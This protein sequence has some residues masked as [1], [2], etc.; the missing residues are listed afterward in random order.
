MRPAGLFP[1]I[2][3][4]TAGIIP[5][6]FRSFADLS[7]V[8]LWSGPAQICLGNYDAAAI[9][10]YMFS[11]IAEAYSLVFSLVAPSIIRSRS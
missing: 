1:A 7:L 11:M 3:I 4:K 8:F 9:K 2:G 10:G 5:G 6:F